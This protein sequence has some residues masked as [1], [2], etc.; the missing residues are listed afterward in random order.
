[1]PQWTWEQIS[2]QD[3]DLNSFGWA[4]TLLS[5]SLTCPTNTYGVPSVCQAWTQSWKAPCLTQEELEDRETPRP[6][7]LA[8]TM[9]AGPQS[10]SGMNSIEHGE[11]EA[12]STPR[13]VQETWSKKEKHPGLTEG[14][15]YAT[16]C[17]SFLICVMGVTIAP[18]GD[19]CHKDWAN[20]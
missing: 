18:T 16:S 1:M 2:L 19:G 15:W 4:Q 14:H 5:D 7:F 17:L 11:W 12:L 13:R 3:P 10:N 9:A 6:T 20:G 8:L